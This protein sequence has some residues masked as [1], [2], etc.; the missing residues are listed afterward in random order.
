MFLYHIIISR[1]CQEG[2]LE[3]IGGFSGKFSPIL[4]TLLNS[5]CNFIAA[6]VISNPI[7]G[8]KTPNPYRLKISNYLSIVV[9]NSPTALR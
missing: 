5:L 2:V 9:L 7:A 4:S 3:S 8:I 6:L 1:A